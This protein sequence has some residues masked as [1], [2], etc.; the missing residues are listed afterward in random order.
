LH[1]AGKRPHT[2]DGRDS[3]GPI[4]KP[5]QSFEAVLPGKA[6]YTFPRCTAAGW[7]LGASLTGQGL[8]GLVTLQ[9]PLFRLHM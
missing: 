5:D 4:Y 9:G 8:V 3:P 7:A 2:S 1:L 6:A